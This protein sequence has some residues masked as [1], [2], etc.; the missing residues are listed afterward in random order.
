[1]SPMPVG[2]PQ[3]ERVHQASSGNDDNGSAARAC[4]L[5]D[6]PES[7][8]IESRNVSKC[9][10][11]EHQF[12]ATSGTYLH[13]HKLPVEMIKKIQTMF[14][15]GMNTRKISI[16]LGIQYKTVWNRTRGIKR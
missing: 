15:M 4:P 2:L 12:S 8:W 11:C 9:K 3:C 14:L 5:C 6:S 7:Y 10:M 1:M 16:A 13:A